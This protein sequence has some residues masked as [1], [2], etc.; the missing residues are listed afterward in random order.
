MPELP[1]VETIKNDLSSEVVNHLIES[2]D[3]LDPRPAI[4]GIPPGDFAARV[5]GACIEQLQRRGKYLIITLSNGLHIVVHLRMTGRLILA[6]PA[7]P[8]SRLAR[9]ILRLS[10]RLE[11]R[12]EDQRKF[13]TV[14]LADDKGIEDLSRRLGP[15]PL[16]EGFTVEVLADRLMKQRRSLKA[17]LL[18]QSVI[19]GLG[20]IY[21]DEAL[22]EARLHPERRPSSLSRMEL[23]RLHAAIRRVLQMGLASRGTTFSDYRDAFGRPGGYQQHLRVYR[24]AGEPCPICG[25]PIVKTSVAGRG[26]HLCS[27]CQVPG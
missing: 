10:G 5:V 27:R 21:V 3:S 12:L 13:A 24:R 9:L 18:D 23:G 15:E 2:V 19:A 11:L 25:R 4:F 17:A 26:T 20:N 6:R 8:P 7:D 14:S 16:S 22:F 1:E